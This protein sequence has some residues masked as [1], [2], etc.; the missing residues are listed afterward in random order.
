MVIGCNGTECNFNKY[1]IEI[2]KNLSVI[3]SYKMDRR[4]KD[5]GSQDEDGTLCIYIGIYIFKN[6]IISDISIKKYV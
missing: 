1:L 3:F 2:P 6:I 4:F 5:N